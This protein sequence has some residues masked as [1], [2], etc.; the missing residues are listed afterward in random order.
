VD[1]AA[2]VVLGIRA[3]VFERPDNAQL[4]ARLGSALTDAVARV[5]GAGICA[6]TV[7]ELVA[8]PPE[9]TFVGGELAV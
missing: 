5:V 8:S 7:V 2:S 6:G 4:T 9:R 3:S 1:T